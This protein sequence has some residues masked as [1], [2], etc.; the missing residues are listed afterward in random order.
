MAEFA[1]RWRFA[2]RK[3]RVLP[4][5]HLDRIKPFDAA[6][7]KRLRVMGSPLL[8]DAVRPFTHT[9]AADC[10]RTSIAAYTPDEVR[11]VREWLFQ[12]RMPFKRKVFLSW[13]SRTAAVTTWKMVVRYWDVFWY[14]SSDDLPVFDASMSWLLYFRHEEEAFFR[15]VSTSGPRQE[16]R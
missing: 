8:W 7:A 11:R 1:L 13:D 12:R 16:R 9:G 5:A 2:E 10:A 4:R 14:P 6:S 15:T 3:D